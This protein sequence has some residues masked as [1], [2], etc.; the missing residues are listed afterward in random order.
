MIGQDQTN[1]VLADKV[2]EAGNKESWKTYLDPKYMEEE[3]KEKQRKNGSQIEEQM[4]EL[5]EGYSTSQGIR[6]AE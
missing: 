6:R 4:L 3:V 2:R 5:H 1:F